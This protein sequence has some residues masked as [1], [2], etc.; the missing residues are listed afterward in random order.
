MKIICLPLGPLQANCYLLADGRGAAAIIDPGGDPEE[1]FSVIEREGWT[2]AA[3]INTHGHVDHVAANRAAVERYRVPL[4]IHRDD[5]PALSDP[6]LNLS[7]LGFGRLDSP[8]PDRELSDGDEI[9]VG[10][11]V[12]EVIATP[13][14]SPGSVCLLLDGGE[15]PAVIFTGDTL[16]AGGVGRTDLPGGSL[17]RLISSIR[18]RLLVFPDRTVIL[19]GHGPSST[20]GEEK[21]SNYFLEQYGLAGGPEQ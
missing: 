4:L 11:L 16:F 10:G 21:C 19:P 14:H 13:G 12:L 8:P 18:D 1:I 5:A 15:E 6:G 2:P 3:V 17:D 20:I 7:S 9:P